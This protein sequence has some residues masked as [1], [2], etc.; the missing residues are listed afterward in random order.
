MLVLLRVSHGGSEGRFR[1]DMRMKV[2]DG[3]KAATRCVDKKFYV[4]RD[5]DGNTLSC[6]T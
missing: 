1:D 3:E 5:V 4:K 2:D 6:G